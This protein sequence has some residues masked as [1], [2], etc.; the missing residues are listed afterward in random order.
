MP[1]TSASPARNTAARQA[2]ID[3][4]VARALAI[5]EAVREDRRARKAAKRA[6]RAVAE[7]TDGASQT[8][9]P[10]PPRPLHEMSGEELEAH[11]NDVLSAYAAGQGYA[12]PSWAGR[13]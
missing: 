9:A 5:D 6:R 4:S 11:A 7:T 1:Q 2:I 13:P 3:E 10:L 12:S 8:A